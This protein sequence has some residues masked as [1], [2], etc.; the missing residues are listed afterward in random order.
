ML[1]T[2]TLTAASYFNCTTLH[3]NAAKFIR[4]VNYYYIRAIEIQF[5]LD[6]FARNI[7]RNESTM[8]ELQLPSCNFAKALSQN[9]PGWVPRWAPRAHISQPSSVQI[10][11]VFRVTHIDFAVP[12]DRFFPF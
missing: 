10:E 9:V 11:P 7:E 2:H 5:M 12:Q 1:L 8:Q 3:N 6:N 4:Y